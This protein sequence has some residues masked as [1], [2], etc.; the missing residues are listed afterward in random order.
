[1]LNKPDAPHIGIALNL[2]AI[3]RQKKWEING[4][5]NTY[6]TCSM[7]YPLGCFV[8]GRFYIGLCITRLIFY[9]RLGICLDL[10]RDFGKIQTVE[11]RCRRNGCSILLYL[12]RL[13]GI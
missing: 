5:T 4:G 1:M 8:H 10:G 9:N 12:N 3:Q 7:L 13:I 6:Y 2:F 11:F